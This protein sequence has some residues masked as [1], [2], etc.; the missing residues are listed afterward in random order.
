MSD[1]DSYELSLRIVGLSENYIYNYLYLSADSW[2]SQNREAPDYRSIYLK[3][4]GVATSTSCW[5]G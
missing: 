2:E 4:D 3:T 1:E 5:R